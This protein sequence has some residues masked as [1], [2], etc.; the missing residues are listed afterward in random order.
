MGANGNLMPLS[1][2]NRIGGLTLRHCFMNVG[3]VDGRKTKHVGMVRNMM[4]GVDRFQFEINVIVALDKGKEDFP[5]IIGRSFLETAKALIDLE[6]KVVFIRSN[7]YYQCYKVTPSS[8][9]YNEAMKVADNWEK[10]KL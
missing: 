1:T 9:A 6:H 8:N 3:L 7:G 10:S 4:I 5:L 2:F